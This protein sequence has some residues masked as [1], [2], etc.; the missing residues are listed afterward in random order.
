MLLLVYNHPMS[1][2]KI[3][4]DGFNGRTIPEGRIVTMMQE[5][6]NELKETGEIR[7]DQAV[8]IDMFRLAV[9]RGML[10]H[11]DVLFVFDYTESK[12]N[13]KGH[14][15]WPQNAAGLSLMED[16]CMELMG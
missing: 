4:W 13:N 6:V 11:E 3:I 2:L 16:Q 12:I 15:T 7:I 1:T 10:K 5:L 9:K 8:L 14:I